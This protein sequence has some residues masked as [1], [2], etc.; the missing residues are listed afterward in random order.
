VPPLPFDWRPDRVRVTEWALAVA[1]LLPLAT[2]VQTRSQ[3][4]PAHPW[5]VSLLAL[6]A[7]TLLG[8]RRAG[9]R[10]LLLLAVGAGLVW[11]WLGG[12]LPPW[13][14]LQQALARLLAGLAPDDSLLTWTLTATQNWLS[15]LNTDPAARNSLLW[16]LALFGVTSATLWRLLA[17]P[18]APVWLLVVVPA[19]MWAGGSYSIHASA[20]PLVL[21]LAAGFALAL[22]RETSR[23]ERRWEQAHYPYSPEI[24]REQ[25][26]AALGIGALVL[27]IAWASPILL[28]PRLSD[29]FIRLFAAPW[30]AVDRL[31]GGR[32]S[33]ITRRQYLPEPA[34]PITAP[35]HSLSGA[36]IVSDE[37]VM[38]VTVPDL[39]G[40]VQ[41]RWRAW[42][43][44]RYDGRAW[45]TSQPRQRPQSGA[46]GQSQ[47]G[48]RQ[49]IQATPEQVGAG[50][51][52]ARG[53]VWTDGA[54]ALVTNSAEDIVGL[55]AARARYTAIS[56]SAQTPA[57]S[58]SSAQRAAYT[59]LPPNLPRRVRLLARLLTRDSDPASIAYRLQQALYQF[60]YDTNIPSPPANRDLV[61][62]FLFDLQRG[63][64][65]YYASAFVVMAR[66][67]GVPARLVIGY[68]PGSYDPATRRYRVTGREAHA[69]AEAWIEGRGWVEYDPT[70]PDKAGYNVVRVAPTSPDTVAPSP[71]VRLTTSRWLAVPLVGLLAAGLSLGWLLHQ[72]R[73]AALDALGAWT[74]IQQRVTRLGSPPALAATPSEQ[75]ATLAA[76]LQC[77]HSRLP[78]RLRLL[79][80]DPGPLLAALAAAYARAR[81]G[82]NH[83]VQAPP[84]WRRV[85]AILW[86]LLLRPRSLN[87]GRKGKRP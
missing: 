50:L 31:T 69:W 49:I 44:D 78:A 63:Y 56:L 39:A 54:A 37:L 11:L 47:P 28:H 34:I 25:L 84:D 73:L 74:L 53:L 70:P 41:L 2:L 1:L 72:R 57:A 5:L 86:W 62:W 10:G 64:C 85:L 13:A 33:E 29:P 35:R 22:W 42:L 16:H 9:W 65:D 36:R 68:A 66:S 45:Q 48:L 58:L 60:P 40:A 27:T 79:R 7:G 43:L 81:Y 75:A 59:Q 12:V 24:L 71:L 4:A 17:A 67:L 38:E 20:D 19:L 82:P 8:W 51:L 76:T 26:I 87:R 14:L 55:P 15:Q 46:W 32:L 21:M 6:A 23:H 30:N 77:I 18:T 61:D 83:A 3:G 80:D 52:A